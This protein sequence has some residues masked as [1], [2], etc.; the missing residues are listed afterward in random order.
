MSILSTLL[1]CWIVL[2]IGYVIGY[3]RGMNWSERHWLEHVDW[4]KKLWGKE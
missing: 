4:L 1:L 2:C 3:V